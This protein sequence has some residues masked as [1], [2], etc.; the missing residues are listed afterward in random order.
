MPDEH[1]IPTDEEIAKWRA[2]WTDERV[3]DVVRILQE[4]PEWGAKKIIEL[5]WY[6]EENGF[7][8]WPKE[9]IEHKLDLNNRPILDL[10][11]CPF[12]SSVRLERIYLPWA[13]LERAWLWGAN[14]SG[15]ELFAVNL[16]ETCLEEA[17]LSK[18]W[19]GWANLSEALLG[20]ANLSG[21]GFLV[22]RLSKAD[23]GWANLSKVWLEK[24]KL[25]KARLD[26]A[27]ILDCRLQGVD[28]RSSEG[29]AECDP[30][31]FFGRTKGKS[32]EETRW[33]FNRKVLK[34]QDLENKDAMKICS[35]IRLCFRDNGLFHNAAIYYEQEEYWRT[36]VKWVELGKWKGFFNPKN[37]GRSFLQAC[38]YFLGEKLM[39][40][41]EHP[42]YIIAW[43]IGS[44]I[45]C[46]IIFFLFGF[47]FEMSQ[48]IFEPM[49]FSTFVR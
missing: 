24:A 4:D 45:F 33:L 42:G 6:T 18:A 8:R 37:F 34:Q 39:G 38:R 5:S 9:E 44:I 40:Y 11:D 19:L 31:T 46:A 20:G 25:V 43:S 3:A 27:R 35:E 26:G 17:N 1:G 41:G 30:D 14:L 15:G 48:G 10:R 21:A 29:Y 36:R 16:S 12:P 2:R 22:A 49:S 23:L 13:R 47:Q 32:Q 28:L 7:E